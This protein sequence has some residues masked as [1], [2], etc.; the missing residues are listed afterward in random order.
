MVM[1]LVR[2]GIADLRSASAII[3]VGAGLFVSAFDQ[4]RVR[5]RPIHGS[6]RLDA[7]NAHPVE[8]SIPGELLH[9]FALDQTV[10]GPGPLPS[11]RP[12]PHG[13]SGKCRP[14]SG[15][16]SSEKIQRE[17]MTPSSYSS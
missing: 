2:T 15:L 14:E 11:S 3:V 12:D 4:Q 6:S 8:E 7:E 10:V 17:T 5:D 16:R 13:C 9:R 1:T